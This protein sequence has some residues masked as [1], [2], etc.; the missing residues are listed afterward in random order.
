MIVGL[1]MFVCSFDSWL[2]LHDGRARTEHI[3]S[4]IFE[5]RVPGC[6]PRNM[7]AMPASWKPARD[8]RRGCEI[9]ASMGS[10]ESLG[11]QP[12]CLFIF[13]FSFC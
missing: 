13:N 5:P 7:P 3:H 9:R 2:V 10:I 11:K 6:H 4:K 12:G 8:Q 1:Y